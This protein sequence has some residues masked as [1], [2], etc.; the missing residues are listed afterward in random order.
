MRGRTRSGIFRPDSHSGQLDRLAEFPVDVVSGV[1][2]PL[3]VWAYMRLPLIILIAT[4]RVASM[5]LSR[6]S[7]V[8]R[9]CR[10]AVEPEREH[11]PPPQIGGNYVAVCADADEQ[12]NGKLQTS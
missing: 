11:I 6:W 4:Y 3:R 2:H 7:R 12:P 9:P 1:A 10:D 8:R 5:T